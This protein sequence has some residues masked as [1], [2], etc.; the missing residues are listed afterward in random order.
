MVIKWVK[1]LS[2]QF[3]VWR[4][5]PAVLLVTMLVGG[6]MLPV[7]GMLASASDPVSRA[8][9]WF[10]GISR[11]GRFYSGGIGRTLLPATA[12]S[13]L[14]RMKMFMFKP[15]ILLTTP[16]WLLSTTQWQ[17]C[18]KLS[19]SGR[20]C[21]WSCKRR[22]IWN[23]MSSRPATRCATASPVLCWPSTPARCWK[24]ILEFTNNPCFA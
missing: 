9:A 15:L 14:H 23:R 19:D 20:P 13:S 7:S 17:A 21:R 24:T 2:R 8:E 12:S 16:V 18:Y 4:L 3:I 10:D 6:T 22:S 11:E 5:R 1:L